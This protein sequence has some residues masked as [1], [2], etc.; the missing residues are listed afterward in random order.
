MQ[1]LATSRRQGREVT[2]WGV[3]ERG[4]NLLQMGAAGSSRVSL[5]VPEG[6]KLSELRLWAAPGARVLATFQA[7]EGG[8]ISPAARRAART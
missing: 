4:D 7:P 5:G 8:R 6:R 3:D 2:T 1:H